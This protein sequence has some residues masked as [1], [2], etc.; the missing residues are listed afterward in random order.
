MSSI[1]DALKKA[2]KE[3]PK[4]DFA[5]ELTKDVDTRKAVSRRARGTRII[6]RA[7]F[8]MVV[9]FVLGF[10]TW[11]ALAHKDFFHE[12]LPGPPPV[13]TLLEKAPEK[14]PLDVAVV[15]PKIEKT[16]EATKETS[17]QPPVMDEGRPGERPVL[18]AKPVKKE[19]SSPKNPP[20][21]L[22]ESH[23]DDAKYKLEAIV[24]A[25]SPESRFA[26]INGQIIRTGQSIEGISITAIAKDHVAVRSSG[27]EWKMSF[28]VE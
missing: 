21:Q 26:V 3:S 9:L 25:E 10:G 18:E 19:E 2:E 14:A 6:Y 8:S 23:P 17:S 11:F 12:K 16:Y 24:W 20:K 28:T 5:P 7:V 27:R 4:L 22:P 15:T 1:L 13:P